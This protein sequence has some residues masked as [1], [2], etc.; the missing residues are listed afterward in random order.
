MTKRSN[1]FFEGL[2]EF[3][4]DLPEAKRYKLAE[5]EAGG[6]AEHGQTGVSGEDSGSR[7]QRTSI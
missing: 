6:S 2:A 5:D 7:P 3:D 1:D 4:E